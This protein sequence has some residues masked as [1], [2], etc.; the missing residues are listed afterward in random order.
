MHDAQ[1]LRQELD[2]AED[3]LK[4]YM[5]V[6]RSSHHTR[7]GKSA[8]TILDGQCHRLSQVA[9]ESKRDYEKKLTDLIQLEE[10]FDLPIQCLAKKQRDL[11]DMKAELLAMKKYLRDVETWKESAQKTLGELVRSGTVL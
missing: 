6:Q 2:K 5:A 11:K 8:T 7:V 1:I 10:S 9:I 4:Q 3:N